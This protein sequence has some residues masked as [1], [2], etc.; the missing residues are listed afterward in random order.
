VFSL[1]IGLIGSIYNP[2]IA[3]P[4]IEAVDLT[5]TSY[6]QNFDTLANSG[7]PAWSN[8]STL[9]GWYLITDTNSSVTSYSPG[10]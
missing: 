8:D 10:T 4:I 1:V 3:S 2:I 7:S 5:G 9:T 6:T